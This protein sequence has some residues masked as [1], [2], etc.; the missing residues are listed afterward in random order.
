MEGGVLGVFYMEEVTEGSALRQKPR[1]WRVSAGRGGSRVDPAPLTL[2]LRLA[3]F[4]S[5]LPSISLFN[6]EEDP[7]G[8]MAFFCPHYHPDSGY[9]Y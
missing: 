3:F 7:R 2:L 9:A 4:S 6:G 8:T 5:S 1:L